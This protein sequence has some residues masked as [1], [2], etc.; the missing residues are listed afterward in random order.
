MFEWADR[1]HEP[2]T[3]MRVRARVTEPASGTVFAPGRT[4]RPGQGLVRQR[5]DRGVEVSVGG[6]G[7][8]HAA[9]L[10]APTGPYHWQEWSFSWDATTLGRQSSAPGRR[11]PPATSSRRCRRGTGS[12]TAT[13]PSRSSYVDVR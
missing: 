4:Y 5:P 11:T 13:T 1:P 9:D 3:I 2:V 10:K 12:A 6:D 8:W 7:V